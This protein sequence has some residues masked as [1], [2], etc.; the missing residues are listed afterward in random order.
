DGPWS[1]VGSGLRLQRC[2]G[3]GGGAPPAPEAAEGEAADPL[4]GPVVPADAI[5]TPPSET[6]RRAAEVESA[7]ANMWGVVNSIDVVG[8]EVEFHFYTSQGAV[9]MV[10]WRRSQ[11]G[12]GAGET[13]DGERFAARLR[14]WLPDYL[15]TSTRYV[16]IALR[17]TRT[18]W[19]M[20]RWDTQPPA[21]A[22]ARPPEGRDLPTA[23]IGYSVDTYGAATQVTGEL[24]PLLRCP[25]GATATFEG[26]VD[27]V[28]ERITAWHPGQYTATEGR[29]RGVTVGPQ[30]HFDSEV[31]NAVLPFTRGLGQRTVRVRLQGRHSVGTPTARWTVVDAGVVRP[32]GPAGP[33]EADQIV[34]DY[35]RMHAEI[36]RRWGEGVRD[37]GIMVAG[38]AAE[39]IILWIV[40]GWIIRGLGAV[41]GAVAPTLARGLTRAGAGFLESLWPRIAQADRAALARLMARVDTA[42]LNALTSAERAELNAL[43]RRLESILGTPLT[44][45]QKDAAREIARRRLYESLN[46]QVAATL[47]RASGARYDVHHLLPLEYAQ[48]FAEMDINAIANTAALNPAVH[49]SVGRIWTAFRTAGARNSAIVTRGNVEEVAAI[50][51]RQYSQWYNVAPTSANLATEVAAAETAAR[52]ELATLFSRLG[53]SL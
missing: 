42:G 23:R 10:S 20:Q 32:P 5:P 18:A 12:T 30:P 13:I 28:D 31:T 24:I 9:T 11:P 7:I 52:G 15:G 8:A 39:Q 38:F 26:T 29:Q 36:I 6:E 37:A 46:P 40:G 44:T 2:N 45:A 25:I 49:T 4:G 43:L 16:S 17:R 48:L 21:G 50:V 51:N 41:F 53:V 14:S 1:P 3:G 22:P 35:H 19:E 33:D 47:R 27:L 34:S